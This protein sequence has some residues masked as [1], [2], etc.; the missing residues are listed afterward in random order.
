M[1]YRFPYAAPGARIGLLGGSFDPA[2]DGHAHITREAIK[3]FQ[4]DFIWWL[5]SPGNPLKERGP[6]P[7]G[8][9]VRFARQ[10]MQHPRVKV[11]SLEADLGTRFT[12]QTLRALQDRFPRVQF[13]WLMGADNLVQFNQWQD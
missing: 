9:R 11:T 3:R 1:R 10:V 4:L 7:L 6:K 13:T 5:V 8:R 12:A 2:H